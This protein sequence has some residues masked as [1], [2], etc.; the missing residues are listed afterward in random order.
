MKGEAE[1]ETVKYTI[2]TGPY[3]PQV[4]IDAVYD[5]MALTEIYVV[6]KGEPLWPDYEI[7]EFRV[8]ITD[9][10]SGSLLD[11]I[12]A[13]NTFANNS[14]RVQTNQPSI[15][16]WHSLTISVSAVSP[17]YNEGKPNQTT[18]SIFTS[19]CLASKYKHAGAHEDTNIKG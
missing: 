12:I 13:T 6:V 5:T 1:L 11:Q 10:S 16:L 9:T 7:S 8:N 19:K 18:I 15:D 3:P 2:T 17:L 14:V 4:T